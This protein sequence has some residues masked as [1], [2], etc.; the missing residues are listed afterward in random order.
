M[1][2]LT[3]ECELTSSD[4]IHDYFAIA[5][6]DYHPSAGRLHDHLAWSWV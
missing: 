6:I 1:N 5:N 4:G 2:D 3:V